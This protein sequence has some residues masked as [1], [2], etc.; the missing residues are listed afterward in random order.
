M[1]AGDIA[2]LLALSGIILYAVFGGADFGGGVWDFFAFGPRAVQQRKAIG[3]AMGPVWETNH[4]WLIF[5]LVALFTCFPPV[6]AQLSIHLYAPLSFALVGIILRGAAFAFLGPA[7]RDLWVNQIWG[8]IFGIASLFTPFFFGACAAGVATGSFHWMG[9]FGITV[10]LFAVALCAQVA[11]IFLAAETRDQLEQDFSK[12]ATFATLSVAA[13]GLTALFAARS[14]NVP[15]FDRLTATWPVLGIAMAA[16]VLI[17]GLLATQHYR[18]ARVAVGIEIA[19]VLCGWFAAQGPLLSH[20]LSLPSISAP[21]QTIA[22]FLWITAAGFVVLLP[23]LW[24]LFSV[25][26]REALPRS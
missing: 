9:L 10:G 11:A 13:I 22:V 14:S 12:R 24:L 7:T 4:I 17:L 26:K 25:F 8:K 16:G 3:A 23:S 20:N 19:A 15:I 21:P 18:T 5:T 6:F 1:N 2:A